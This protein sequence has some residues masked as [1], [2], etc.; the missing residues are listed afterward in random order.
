MILSKNNHG[1]MSAD[2]PPPSRV[3]Y[4]TL[5]CQR[6]QVRNSGIKYPI[7]IFQS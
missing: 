5:L 4:S 6:L 7:D 3:L 1:G 2:S